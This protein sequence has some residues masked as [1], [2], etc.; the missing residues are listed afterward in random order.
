LKELLGERNFDKSESGVNDEEEDDVRFFL[1]L[2]VSL[3]GVHMVV[4]VYEFIDLFMYFR[5]RMMRE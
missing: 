3:L 2:C 5:M 1:L 4:L